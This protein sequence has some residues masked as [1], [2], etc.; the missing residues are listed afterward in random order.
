MEVSCTARRCQ[1]RRRDFAESEPG[2]LPWGSRPVRTRDVAGRGLPV[3]SLLA[4]MAVALVGRRAALVGV[5]VRAA[6][7]ALGGAELG[8]PVVL[9]VAA[10][11]VGHPT[12]AA[13]ALL[14]ARLDS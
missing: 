12:V 8:A 14:R 13:G 3:A 1:V 11:G 5:A 4:R 7:G 2:R 6:G 10:L 9:A